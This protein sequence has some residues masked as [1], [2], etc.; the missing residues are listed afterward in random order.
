MNMI[1]SILEGSYGKMKH[2]PLITSFTLC[3]GQ[4]VL[5]DMLM[6]FLSL[7]C[8]IVNLDRLAYYLKTVE[9][10]EQYDTGRLTIASKNIIIFPI[11][12]INFYIKLYI[13]KKVPKNPP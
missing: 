8:T 5:M 7:N 13:C 3:L 12:L 4:L 1:L 9:A 10:F 2:A 11:A 6:S